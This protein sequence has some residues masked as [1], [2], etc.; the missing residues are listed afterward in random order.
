MMHIL[1]DNKNNN[2]VFVQIYQTIEVKYI[3]FE[4]KRNYNFHYHYYYSL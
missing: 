1:H 2:F 4:Q 3:L